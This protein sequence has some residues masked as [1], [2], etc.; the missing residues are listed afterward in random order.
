MQMTPHHRQLDEK[1]GTDMPGVSVATGEFCEPVDV[2]AIAARDAADD[3]RVDRLLRCVSSGYL[4][5]GCSCRATIPESTVTAAW[6]AELERTGV[7]EDRFFRFA[8]RDGVWLAFGLRDGRVRGLYCPEHSAER[9]E[10][11]SL[12]GAGVAS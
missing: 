10:R 12:D 1:G 6:S 4:A 8:W 9:A 11:T 5:G 7:Y 3:A 2:T